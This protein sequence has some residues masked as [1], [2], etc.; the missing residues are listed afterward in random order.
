MPARQSVLGFRLM[1]AEF[2]IRDLL[3]PPRAMLEE[4]G[5]APGMCVLDYGCGPGSYVVAA[6][7][8]VGQAGKVYALDVHPLA[9]ASV[10]RLSV[11]KCLAN[12][13]TILSDCKTGLTDGEVDVV[14]LYD[15]LH[16]VHDPRPLLDELHRVLKPKGILS[17]SDHHLRERE[18]VSLLAHGGAFRLLSKGKRTYAFSLEKLR[19]SPPAGMGA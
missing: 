19:M 14:L 7:G 8:M 17:V 2:R 5:I 11:R 3:R 9:I 16:D 12:V 18:I 1:A 10:R 6:A 13:V 15:V 4:A